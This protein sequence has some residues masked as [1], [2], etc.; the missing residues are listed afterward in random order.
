MAK[1]IYFSLISLDGY[2]EDKTAKFDCAI[3]DDDVHAFANDL[4]RGAG[5]FL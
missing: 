3:P 2:I 4:I 5:T 1:L